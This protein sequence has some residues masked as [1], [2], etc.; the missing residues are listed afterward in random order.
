MGQVASDPGEDDGS[1]EGGDDHDCEIFRALARDAE[2]DQTLG[3][4]L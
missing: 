4:R 2:V 3:E 1:F